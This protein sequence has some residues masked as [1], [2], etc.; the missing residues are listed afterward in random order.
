MR[1]LSCGRATLVALAIIAA[2]PAKATSFYLAEQSIR[3]AGHAFSGEATDQGSDML[4]W[5]PASIAGSP[6][7]HAAIGAALILPDANVRDAG[8]RIQR[9]GQPAA[10]VGGDLTP[11][12]PAKKGILPSASIAVP[13]NDRIT[14]GIALSSPFSLTTDYE[15]DSW[16]RYIADKTKLITIDVQPSIGIKLTEQF[17]VGAGLNIEYAD[18]TLQKRLPNVLATLPDGSQA[19]KGNALDLGFSA[20]AQYVGERVSLGLSYKSAIKHKFGGDITISGLLGPLA[21]SNTKFDTTATFMTPWQIIGAVRVKATDALTLNAQIS[22]FGWAKFD[23]IR[24][25]VPPG[26]FVPEDYRDTWTVAAG[27]DYQI[28]PE[29][30]VRG[31]AYRDQTPTQDGRRDPNVP[32]GNRTAIAAGASTKLNETI[33]LDAAAEY[34]LFDKESVDRQAIAFEGTPVAT[35]ILTNGTTDARA[36]VFGVGARF[37]F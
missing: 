17:R 5:N 2:V 14:V 15:A 31:G 19:L 32:D 20:G 12:N 9:P 35:S 27:F 10:P 29:I 21:N 18:A 36:I 30:T 24:L 8:T 1:I 3:A 34:I 23:R 7:T 26:A 11:G 25:A 22:R 6:R 16:T 4:W 13:L 37:A 33:T 28:N